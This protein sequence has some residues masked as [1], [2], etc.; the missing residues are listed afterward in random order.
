MASSSEA[1]SSSTVADGS[2]A[3]PTTVDPTTGPP[4]PPALCSLEAVD[5]LADPSIVEMGDEEG[6][7][8]TVIGE[9]LLR[10]CGCHYSDDPDVNVDYMSDTVLINTWADFHVP[11]VGIFPM[12]F[13]DRMVWEATAVRVVDQMPVPMPAFECG[14]EG[15]DGVITEADKALFEAWFDAGAPDGANFP[16]R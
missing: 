4:P 9:A 6:L 3:A 1:A 10:N 12:G 11:F 16:P 15:E 7:L 5:P 13:E 14:V 8:P 2:T